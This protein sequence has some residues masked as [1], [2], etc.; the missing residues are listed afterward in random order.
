M[1]GDFLSPM[2]ATNANDSIHHFH[3]DGV[4]GPS[5]QNGCADPDLTPAELY[6]A[7]DTPKIPG[8]NPKN[9]RSLPGFLATAGG[10]FLISRTD[11][12]NIGPMSAKTRPSGMAAFLYMHTSCPV[13][14]LCQ[15]ERNVP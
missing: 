4:L 5:T 13:N 12:E 6:F 8:N 1:I 2:R 3:R 9:T 15:I 11:A 10:T 14:L 7:Q